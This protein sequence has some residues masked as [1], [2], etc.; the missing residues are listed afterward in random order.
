MAEARR[1]PITLLDAA[2]SGLALGA[3]LQFR[4]VR[5]LAVMSQTIPAGMFLIHLGWEL[6][7]LPLLF[8]VALLLLWGGTEL[9]S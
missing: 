8:V 6:V 4:H 9:W 3:L 7:K 1:K 5:E 2:Q